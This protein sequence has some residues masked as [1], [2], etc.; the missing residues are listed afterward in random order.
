MIL[1]RKIFFLFV[2]VLF[3]LIFSISCQSQVSKAHEGHTNQSYP[4]TV[5]PEDTARLWLAEGP[6]N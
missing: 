2:P 5:F 6:I 1:T 3:C 4:P